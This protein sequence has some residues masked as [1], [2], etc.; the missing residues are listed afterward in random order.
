MKL[1]YAG[2][3]V[4]RVSGKESRSCKS[5]PCRAERKTSGGAVNLGS[6]LTQRKENIRRKLRSSHP[7]RIA[8]E[9]GAHLENDEL[10]LSMLGDHYVITTSDY[11]VR[12]PERSCSEELEALIL[13]YLLR[14]DT[15]EASEEWIAFREIPNGDFYSDNFKK[16]TEARLT[17]TF[18][19]QMDSFAQIAIDL[20]GTRVSMGD[21]GFSFPVLPRFEMA[22]VFWSGGEEFR[23]KVNVL[24][25]AN[26]S[27]CLPTEGLSI[28]GKKLCNKFV[29]KAGDKCENEDRDRG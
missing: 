24:F 10:H 21:V 18:Q 17:R 6:Q 28:L 3:F 7:E 16:N 14:A 26:A 5:F 29:K 9:S 19:G 2:K 8:R 13:D 11:V 22:I 12:S 27:N 20:G 25:E 23:D 1:T 15:S 4:Y